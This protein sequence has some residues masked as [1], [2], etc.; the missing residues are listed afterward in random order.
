MLDKL[1]AMF[2]RFLEQNNGLILK[3]AQENQFSILE[4]KEIKVIEAEFRSIF[5]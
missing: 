1:I 3:R 4:L 5:M 2:I